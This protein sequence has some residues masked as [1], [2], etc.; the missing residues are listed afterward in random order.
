MTT[1]EWENQV[2]AAWA[3]I[4]ERDETEFR[5]LMEKLVE[6]RVDGGP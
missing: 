4:D 1:A 2:A 3:S 6:G 5:L